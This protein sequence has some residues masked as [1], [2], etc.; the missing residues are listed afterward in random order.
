M[1]KKQKILVIV[2]PTASGKSAL[3]VS[4]ARKYNG[5]I[6]SADSRQVYRGLDIGTGKVTKREMGNIPHHMLDVSS[7]KKAFSA[8]DFVRAARRAIDDISRHG[9][10]PI[11][12]G[13]TGFYID[14]LIGRI[15]LPDVPP[16]PALRARLEKK[17]AAQLFAMLKRRDPRRARTIEPKHKRRLIR[18]LEIAAALGKSPSPRAAVP[19]DTLWLGIAPPLPELDEKIALRLRVR[20]KRGM[21]SEAKR[22]HAR[23]LSYKRMEELGLEYRSLARFLQGE[24]TQEQMLEELKH[25]IRR[26]A[27]KQIAYWKRNQNIEWF[28]SP[29]SKE[30]TT[31]V[32]KWLKR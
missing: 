2:G 13:G 31:Q 16:N 8:D 29:A 18:A 20:M 9:K 32:R 5:E 6:I 27:R 28:P 19:Y 14:A 30:I 26:Y 10:L 12:A 24:I 11:V 22:L 7:P 15:A 1:L 3:A 25:A 4:L 21:I 23:G 17:T